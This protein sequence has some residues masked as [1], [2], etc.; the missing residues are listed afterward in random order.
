MKKIAIL[1]G[2]FDP[3]HNGHIIILQTLIDSERFDEVWLMP[4]GQQPFKLES[5][6]AKLDRLAMCQTISELMPDIKLSTLEIDQEGPSYTFDTLTLLKHQYPN[7]QFYWT[8]GYDNLQSIEQWYK[9]SELLSHF[10]FI[11]VNRGGYSPEMSETL[12]NQLQT[13]YDT[14][15]E[16][17]VIPNIELSSSLLRN[18]VQENKSL[19]GFTVQPIIDYISCHKIYDN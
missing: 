5:S 12:I 14:Q 17:I 4:A 13:T 15:F 1:G 6:S 11:V 9:G 8:I 16:T 7:S 3:I 18:R 10:N 19:F 2:T